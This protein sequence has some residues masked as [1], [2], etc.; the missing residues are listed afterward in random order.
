MPDKHNADYT[1]WKIWFE[2]LIPYLNSDSINLIGY[3]L[4]GS[5]LVKYLA[6]TDVACKIKQLHLV[7]PAVTEADCPGLGGFA[8]NPTDWP[9]LAKVAKEI[10][11]YHST[12]DE[13]VPFAQSE[14]LAK[15]LPTATLHSFTDRGH[16]FQPEFPELLNTL[17]A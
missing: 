14:Q 4:G 3:S 12:D 2:K 11:I 10:H 9:K 13:I 5:F 7:A 6:T 8:S 16:F 17:S 15:A 1:A